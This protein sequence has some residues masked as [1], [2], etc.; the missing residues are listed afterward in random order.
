MEKL[1]RAK[2]PLNE[3]EDREREMGLFLALEALA[4]GITGKRMLWR[5]LA[6]AAE[7]VTQ[8]R[9]PDYAALEER[10]IEQHDRVGNAAAGSRAESLQI[11]IG[12]EPASTPD[13]FPRGGRR[14]NEYQKKTAQRELRPANIGVLFC[15]P[16]NQPTKHT[17]YGYKLLG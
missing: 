6:A 5:A 15:S 17:Y 9:G 11:G 1:S 12:L 16:H 3:K 2:I 14:F 7:S 10:A 8:L 4:L 13:G